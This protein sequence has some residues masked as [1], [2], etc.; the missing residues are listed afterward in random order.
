[1]KYNKKDEQYNQYFEKNLD[2]IVIG[3]EPGGCTVSKIL[4]DDSN[5]KV[6]M[7]EATYD[8]DDKD[9]NH[10]IKQSYNYKNGGESAI[11]GEQ[12][13]KGTSYYYNKKSEECKDN[14]WCWLNV[15][16]TFDEFF[17]E[18]KIINTR[19]PSIPENKADQ[20]ILNSIINS[21]NV[22]K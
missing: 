3:S 21:L 15:K 6:F 17:G 1:M 4:T 10:L 14:D 5:I 8:K 22:D 7:I 20:K 11:N 18:E 19:N 2:Y 9:N 13:V 16:N 12:Y